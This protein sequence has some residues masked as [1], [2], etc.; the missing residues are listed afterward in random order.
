V[1]RIKIKIAGKL[2]ELL[3]QGKGHVVHTS[4]GFAYSAR[5]F[6]RSTRQILWHVTAFSVDRS[7]V[8]VARLKKPRVL[9]CIRREA[10]VQTQETVTIHHDDTAKNRHQEMVTNEAFLILRRIG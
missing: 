1:Y 9:C 8:S 3:T 4:Q 10:A 5:S 2:G 6:M 7:T